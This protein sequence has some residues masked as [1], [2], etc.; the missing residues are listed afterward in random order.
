VVDVGDLACHEARPALETPAMP[1]ENLVDRVAAVIVEGGSDLLEGKLD[2]PQGL[3]EACVADLIASVAP[4]SADG[5]DRGWG[6]DADIVVVAQG[7]HRQPAD[8]GETP[9]RHRLILS[10]IASMRPRA[11]R[12]SSITLGR[13][14]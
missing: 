14:C 7:M 3:D 8:A 13:L 12:G 10:H 2:P 5:V 1:P 9:D 4:I 6:E 11:T